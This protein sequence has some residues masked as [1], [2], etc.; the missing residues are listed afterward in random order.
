MF[1]M[2]IPAWGATHPAISLYST[3]FLQSLHNDLERMAEDADGEA[4]DIEWGM[5]QMV[6][7]LA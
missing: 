1:S 6:L 2:N 4:S 3:P 7:E 5:R